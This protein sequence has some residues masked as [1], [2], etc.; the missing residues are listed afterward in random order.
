MA[1]IRARRAAADQICPDL[2]SR[3]MRSRSSA[4]DFGRTSGA[5]DAA[6][7][8]AVRCGIARDVE[9]RRFAR[10]QRQ[11]RVLD[12]GKPRDPVE[13]RF[14]F[15]P[16]DA[17]IFGPEIGVT[18]LAPIRQFAGIEKLNGKVKPAHLAVL[19]DV[20]DQF[21]LQALRVAFLQ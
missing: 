11:L 12:Q 6:D 10:F 3:R 13:R 16:V 17:R 14:G 18:G 19:P 9:I 1:A 5:I 8:P 2:S 7:R 21:V 15:A 4:C 20:P